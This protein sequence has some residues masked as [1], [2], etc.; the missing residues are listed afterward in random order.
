VSSKGVRRI[1]G[2]LLVGTQLLGNNNAVKCIM[3]FS[4]D[5][6]V[7]LEGFLL[8]AKFDFFQY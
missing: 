4:F 8:L 3:Y 6:T 2:K 1:G 7:A 5:C